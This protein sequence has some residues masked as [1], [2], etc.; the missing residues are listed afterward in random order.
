[1]MHEKQQEAVRE[2][3]PVT[4]TKKN[5]IQMKRPLCSSI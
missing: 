1:M 4:F 3:E 5:N 2:K